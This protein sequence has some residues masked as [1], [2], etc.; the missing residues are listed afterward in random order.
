M[1]SGTKEYI[2]NYDIRADVSK[3]LPALQ[4]FG[5]V[6]KSLYNN[7]N[8]LAEKTGIP[9][10]NEEFNSLISRVS[11]LKSE[12]NRIQPSFNLEPLRDSLRTMERMVSE[13]AL[14]MQRV[15]QS[16]LSGTNIPQSK[17]G[18][19]NLKQ[20][21][22][23]LNNY[24]NEIDRVEGII[25]EKTK[26]RNAML[27]PDDPKQMGLRTQPYMLS[28]YGHPRDTPEFKQLDDEIKAQ[29]E[30]LQ[31]LKQRAAKMRGEYNTVAQQ[32]GMPTLP[33]DLMSPKQW[34]NLKN[35]GSKR[36][37]TEAQRLIDEYTTEVER[38][39]QEVDAARKKLYDVFEK[40]KTGDG[41]VDRQALFSDDK[42]NKLTQKLGAN[43]SAAER[44]Y[45]VWQSKLSQIKDDKAT[46]E[47]IAKQQ[48]IR[49]DYAKQ[50]RAYRQSAPMEDMGASPVMPKEIADKIEQI[51][52][53]TEDF[54]KKVQIARDKWKSFG[55]ALK[56][57]IQIPKPAI[58]DVQTSEG[59]PLS[60]YFKEYDNAMKQY[61]TSDDMN[62]LVR[63]EELK[64]KIMTAGGLTGGQ[65]NK[66][67]EQF[68]AYKKYEADAEKWL[69]KQGR[70]RESFRNSQ[71]MKDL[72]TAQEK[73]ASAYR[74]KSE[75]N[76]LSANKPSVMPAGTTGISSQQIIE[77]A[78]TGK[79]TLVP[80]VAS[81]KTAIAAEKFNANLNLVP[82]IAEL[83]AK[84]N[85][86]TFN[87][88]VTP[89]IAKPKGGRA[90]AATGAIGTLQEE[91]NALQRSAKA[92]ITV[93]TQLERGGLLGRAQS[94][95]NTLQTLANR[96]P[97]TYK[98][99]SDGSGGF[100][101]NQALA[102]L[103]Q[104]AK[105]RPVPFRMIHDGSGAFNLNQAL[106]RLQAL[107]AT[108]PIAIRLNANIGNLGTTI[109]KALQTTSGNVK[110]YPI[111]I[112]PKVGQ[113]SQSIKAALTG[114]GGAPRSFF[115]DV[116][117]RTAGLTSSISR[118]LKSKV[119][120]ISAKLDT[121]T[122]TSGVPLLE[123]LQKIWAQLPKTGKRTYTVNLKT[124]GIGD[125]AKIERVI[126]L[127]NSLP[128][129][130]TKNY[131]FNTTANGGNGGVGRNNIAPYGTGGGTSGGRVYG[132]RGGDIYTRSRAWAYPFTG[133]TSFGARTPAA[134]DMMKG[135][136]MM[137]GIGGAMGVIGSSFS[138]AVSY[139]STMETAKAILRDNYKGRNFNQDY[140][141][142]VSVVRDVAMRT[143]FTAPEAAD[144]TRFMAMAGLDIP[145]IKDAIAPIAD[146][147]AIS[148]AD[149][150]MVA[151]K[152]TNIMTEFKVAPSQM[153]NLADM[154][155]KTFTSTNTDMIMLAE[156]LQ[157]A[158]P[159][160]FAS[161]QSLAET[162]A[163]IG[164]MGNSGIQ[165][166]MAGTTM[167]MMLQNLY[168]PNKNQAKFMQ[169][170][171]LQT[172][173]ANGNRRSLFDILSDIS[174]LTGG[175]ADSK[176]VVGNLLSGKDE[177]NNLDTFDAA[178]KLFRVTASAG[179][180]SLLG[181]IDKVAAL[182]QQIQS[183]NGNSE[184]VSIAKQNTVAGMW[185]QAK[186]AFTEAVVK[187]FEDTDMQKYIKDT[188]G[189]LVDYLKQPEFIKTMKDLF[190]LIKGIASVMATF[191]GWWIKLYQTLPGLVK[192]VAIGQ[193]FF[194]QIG[195]LITPFVQLI[196]LVSSFGRALKGV[197]GISGAT[198]GLSA[199]T[200][201]GE[202]M[203]REA[204]TREMVPDSAFYRYNIHQ[205]RV[206]A[207]GFVDPYATNL[208]A[209]GGK[210]ESIYKKGA[211]AYRY[212]A[213]KRQRDINAMMTGM[214]I[215]QLGKSE[216]DKLQQLR[217][218][219]SHYDYMATQY[220]LLAM[221]SEMIN[222]QRKSTQLKNADLLSRA[223]RRGKLS[224][225]N[226]F[227][228]VGSA[229]TTA[230]TANTM[231]A[232]I[233][234]AWASIKGGLTSFA[235]SLAKIAGLLFNPI[236]LAVGA[237]GAF[238]IAAGVAA[239]NFNK[240]NK[241]W[242]EGIRNS[243][244][245]FKEELTK[246]WGTDTSLT[247]IF[248]HIQTI[249]INSASVNV[250]EGEIVKA[251]SKISEDENLK[252]IYDVLNSK[253]STRE[254]HALGIT[255]KVLSGVSLGTFEEAYNNYIA[256]VSGILP[257]LPNYEQYEKYLLGR[258]GTN[259]ANEPLAAAAITQAIIAQKG[260]QSGRFEQAKKQAT[261]LAQNFSALSIDEQLTQWDAYMAEIHK[262]AEA[263]N[264]Q[265]HPNLARITAD[266]YQQA[267]SDSPAQ[268]YEYWLGSYNSI[269]KFI[270]ESPALK[271]VQA[272]HALNSGVE[273]KTE[274]WWTAI[275]DIIGAMPFNDEQYNGIR[276]F[277]IP[278][279]NGQIDY[280]LLTQKIS[281]TGT[282]LNE[283][284]GTYMSWVSQVYDI[285]FSNE[286]LAQQLN[287]VNFPS[288]E[289]IIR[290]LFGSEALPQWIRDAMSLPSA[291]GWGGWNWGG[292]TN[293][294]DHRVNSFL[295]TNNNNPYTSN[296]S[297]DPN[298]NKPGYEFS[299]IQ[300][301]W[302][303]SKPVVTPTTA[304]TPAPTATTNTTTP[305]PIAYTPG[306][307]NSGYES[308]YAQNAARPTQV[309]INID[310]LMSTDKMMIA[311]DAEERQL[312][313]MMEDKIEQALD[314]LK[315]Q[316]VTSLQSGD[317]G[318]G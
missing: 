136:G 63:A 218:Q 89:Q 23:L 108:R 295:G 215:G 20:N 148:D 307:L 209:K 25:K 267:L 30:Y 96:H 241:A 194:H 74:A 134:F 95:Y 317:Y 141:S 47:E 264:P 113:L 105:S 278:T 299:V 123:R 276:G 169:S 214:T 306:D 48:K 156:S 78:F 236:T 232:A 49:N 228:G 135:M 71:T 103:T 43:L 265:N 61:L 271:A 260:T 204:R 281:A 140:D 207:R 17:N 184:A 5:N 50:L 200:H 268:Y 115:I 45:K 124:T 79:L 205:Q 186:S 147:A 298:S 154:M 149:L 210:F 91:I 111:D 225:G 69:E 33:N 102:R 68:Q 316:I 118:V 171:G 106:S 13:S 193:A 300:N 213:F 75:A 150:G 246:A 6:I 18:R 98:L 208:T 129:G 197:G 245:Q 291:T 65:F 226:F 313:G 315:G 126:A 170:I 308:T 292:S 318:M 239:Y 181:N 304:A 201:G 19:S 4:E 1:G 238:A 220:S 76:T 90:A 153:R 37:A 83:R 130:T 303:P 253:I 177:K 275:I 116:K 233:G 144:A 255:H 263:F 157:Y 109:Q 138:D 40:H 51:P 179:G 101:L 41:K 11:T 32:V 14:N 161:G 88:N 46:K 250:N 8:N 195:F 175:T 85:A 64:K 285:I 242:Q 145:M 173:D 216:F 139:Q 44:K 227:R 114:T 196:G 294:I 112:K 7:S 296:Y 158:G 2:V 199:I 52:A 279:R 202:L 164:I 189:G 178:S 27:P 311:S 110:S 60:S 31:T 310:K 176:N 222:R 289:E 29:K 131:R 127:V 187:V 66:Q 247:D 284:L 302:V 254:S 231:S 309:V 28:K 92:P 86:E 54:K 314:I 280:T 229:F 224:R 269:M 182:I 212:E 58:L 100:S 185:A 107:A 104:L 82:L 261:D 223:A 22:R 288:K 57:P 117:A 77:Q 206:R 305:K 211:K 122:L 21:Q 81:A 301:K 39:R 167:R 12:F 121:S 119:F 56:A 34:R 258:S 256:P 53:L 277:T 190:E 42:T 163:M 160:A 217:T 251:A 35:R 282:R 120:N 3:A 142:M 59:K 270:D 159:M 162:L 93:G 94:G 155:T 252:D 240:Q 290:R 312:A 272:I 235:M 191:V 99:A 192:W 143:K 221:Q 243:G 203:E 9:R 84:L 87:V 293:T 97:I 274:D 10:I 165:A 62:Q 168:N 283:D 70:Y 36:G 266:N 137:M 297:R 166:S 244:V 180:A 15:L 72:R 73:L 287:G 230:F 67:F 26:S 152:M 273:E 128:P 237:I 257:G 259:A 183:A 262:I 38:A 198:A 55:S 16:A 286:G 146:I 188:L 151:D 133:N 174:R 248:E 24:L 249:N 219:H 125:I 234:D 172:R 132:G 80:D